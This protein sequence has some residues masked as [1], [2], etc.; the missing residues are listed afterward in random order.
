MASVRP[1]ASPDALDDATY[2]SSSA[3]RRTA[4]RV[5]SDTFGR[6]RSARETVA[7]DTPVARATSSMPSHARPRLRSPGARG[8]ASSAS[9]RRAAMMR[10]RACRDR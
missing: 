10:R 4:A 8:R 9:G 7:V 6:P 2:P 1:L 5:L 3:A